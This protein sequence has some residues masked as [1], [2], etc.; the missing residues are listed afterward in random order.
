LFINGF[1]KKIQEKGSIFLGGILSRLAFNIII[2]QFLDLINQ[3]I[4]HYRHGTTLTRHHH[5]GLNLSQ[6]IFYFQLIQFKTL[7]INAV[8]KH[9]TMA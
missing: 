5:Q 3:R 7:L 6:G 1:D 9:S 2:K 8:K 4:D